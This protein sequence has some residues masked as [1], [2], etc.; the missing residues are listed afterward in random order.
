[1]KVVDFILASVVGLNSAMI[2]DVK[3]LTAEQLAWKP[4]PNANPI[5][6]I[7]WH[8]MRS[9]DNTIQ[10][11]QGKPSLWESEKWYEKM[12][13]DLKVS[14]TGSDEPEVD[15]VAALPLSQLMAYAERVTQSAADY[16]KTL[17]E[18]ELD[19]SDPNRPKRTIAVSLRAFVLG[20]G[21]WHA[22]EIKYLRGMQGMPFPA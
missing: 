6:F 1:M 20:H 9:E 5:G 17:P 2:S 19:L 13:I 14:G 18:S 21:W 10:G 16:L 22:G 4:A 8:F 15:K 12:G 3:E 11:Y 7:F